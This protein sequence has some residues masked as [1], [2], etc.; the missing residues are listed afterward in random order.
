MST[1]AFWIFAGA[2]SLYGLAVSGIGLFNQ[3]I[4]AEHG[5]TE[6]DYHRTLTVSTL[7]SLAAQFATGALASRWSFQRLIALA[8]A[9]YA[10][11]LIGLT[12]IEQHWQLWLCVTLLGSAG[13]IIIVTFFAIWTHAFG[14]AHLGRIQGIAQ[15]TTVFASSLGPVLFA[16]CKAHDWG[17][18][19]QNTYN[20]ILY[21]LAG[22]VILFGIAAWFVQLPN[23]SSESDSAK[24]ALMS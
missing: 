16:E 23:R 11:G 19:G 22:I 9:L 12:C 3:S 5:F 17:S 4:L 2:T 20:P 1:P 15:M 18:L 13:G 8:M 24:T 21:L 14:R 6:A 10:A 7:I